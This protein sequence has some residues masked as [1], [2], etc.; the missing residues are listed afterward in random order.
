MTVIELITK[1]SHPLPNR[2]FY[3]VKVHIKSV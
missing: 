3:L 2:A 1:V